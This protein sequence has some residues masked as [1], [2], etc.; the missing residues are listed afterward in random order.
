[1]STMTFNIDPFFF[2]FLKFIHSPVSENENNK[3]TQMPPV[4]TV[5]LH[6]FIQW[7]YNYKV[8]AI[9]QYWKLGYIRL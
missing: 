6:Q 9:N 5:K 8:C 7:K 3:V 1:M 2:F 4:K